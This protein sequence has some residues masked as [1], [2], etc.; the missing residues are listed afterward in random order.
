MNI[1]I[2]LQTV[3]IL[4][5]SAWIVGCASTGMKQSERTDAYNAYITT[6]KLEPLKRI[7]AFRFDSWSSLGQS[8]LII[9]TT[10]NKPYLITLKTRCYDLR[11]AQVIG[12]DN[13]GSTLQAG[14]DSIVVD[15]NHPQKCYIDSIYKITKEQKQALLNIGDDDGVEKKPETQKPETK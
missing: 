3:S 14:F 11:M 10:F 2:L 5:I 12:I 13:T 9:K 4:I 15:R 6:E 8:H 7:T 1:K